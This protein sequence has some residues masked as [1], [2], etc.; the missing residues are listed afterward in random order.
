MK[1]LI[2]VLLVVCM[3][4]GFPVP[5]AGAA[6]EL[7]TLQKAIVQTALSYYYKGNAVQYDSYYLGH[8]NTVAG[9]AEEITVELFSGEN[10]LVSVTDT[11]ASYAARLA[12]ADSAKAPMADAIV[13]YGM[14][15]KAVGK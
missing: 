3:M 13:L 12:A 8:G 6:D 1:K 11:I 15:A 5:S 14:A 10:L 2:S 4:A 9:Y 7:T